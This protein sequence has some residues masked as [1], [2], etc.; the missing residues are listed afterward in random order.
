MDL[1]FE[2]LGDY[3][4][5]AAAPGLFVPL[6]GG[7][8]DST[9]PGMMPLILATPAGEKRQ[10]D[11]D[12]NAT[13]GEL[14]TLVSNIGVAPRGNTTE[15]SEK[16][17]PFNLVFGENTLDDDEQQL[18]KTTIVDTYEHAGGMLRAIE[19]AS[20]QDENAMKALD[21]TLS[22]VGN[23]QQGGVD[24]DQM[25]LDA[26]RAGLDTTGGSPEPVAEEPVPDQ[27]DAGPR[28]DDMVWN[29][30][31]QV[32]RRAASVVTRAHQA[33]ISD[34]RSVPDV[35]QRLSNKM[36]DVFSP[37]AAERVSRNWDAITPRSSK[38]RALNAEL[39][40][41]NGGANSGATWMSNLIDNWERAHAKDAITEQPNSRKRN[42]ESAQLG[43]PDNQEWK[44]A[45]SRAA[46]GG[47]RNGMKDKLEYLEQML[48]IQ[49]KPEDQRRN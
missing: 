15:D 40:M 37:K 12:V 23:V 21:S 27:Q 4:E 38:L 44:Q 24:F 35:L 7:G 22:V 34:R 10:V 17:E 9:T 33:S 8:A 26:L 20:A 25:L 48:T 30:K 19:E 28:A 41:N 6:L 47:Q 3:E 31:V 1:D 49:V 45:Y 14:K 42:A 18:F 11:V 39:S 16:K 43:A 32:A 13:V 29:P 2:Q 46:A 36:P 5:E